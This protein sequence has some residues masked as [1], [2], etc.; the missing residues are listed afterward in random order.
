MLAYACLAIG[1]VFVFL[2]TGMILDGAEA[3]IPVTLFFGLCAAVAVLQ[4]WPGLLQREAHSAA[5]L[6]AR[7]PGPVRLKAAALKLWVFSLLSAVFGGVLLW[8]LL[9]E[10][11]PLLKQL[12]LW[13]GAVL[14]LFAAAMLIVRAAKDDIFLRLSRNGFETRLAWSS[15]TIRWQDTSEF[16]VV[17]ISRNVPK[18]IVFDDAAVDRAG[19]AGLNRRFVGRNSS[20]AETYGLTHEALAELLN[21][22]RARALEQDAIFTRWPGNL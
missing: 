22:W 6:L 20:L 9:H 12:I 11:L 21:A 19:A 14:S 16:A 13:P 18:L 10:P 8:M 4:I 2:G 15:K 17:S 7:Y 1:L 5:A 3:G